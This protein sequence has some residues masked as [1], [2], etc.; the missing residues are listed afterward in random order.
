VNGEIGDMVKAGV[1]EAYEVKRNVILGASEIACMLVRVD[2]MV[3]GDVLK[4]IREDKKRM[5]QELDIIREE[6]EYLWK[7][8][9][10]GKR[11]D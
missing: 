5:E 11:L 3:M 2:E 6:A 1:V 4:N 10:K 7:K 9:K 8:S